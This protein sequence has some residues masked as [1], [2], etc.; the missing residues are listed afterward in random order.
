MPLGRKNSSVGD[1]H[2][3]LQATASRLMSYLNLCLQP[4]R[5]LRDVDNKCTQRSVDFA[6]LWYSD[7]L[8]PLLPAM[9]LLFLTVPSQAMMVGWGVFIGGSATR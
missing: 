6:G 3:F 7:P 2:L 8:D 9:S 4:A 5:F 1:E